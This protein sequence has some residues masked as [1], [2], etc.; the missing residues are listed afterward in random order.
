MDRTATFKISVFLDSEFFMVA[1]FVAV[2]KALSGRLKE[3]FYE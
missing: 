1:F 3:G 2:M